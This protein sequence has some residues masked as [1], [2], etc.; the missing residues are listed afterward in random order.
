MWPELH[1][2]PSTTLNL[3]HVHWESLKDT[4]FT[5]VRGEP[6]YW[7]SPLLAVF[8]RRGMKMKMLPSRCSDFQWDPTFA[9]AKCQCLTDR[10]SVNTFT[11]MGGR[12]KLLISMFCLADIFG[13]GN[14]ITMFLGMKYIHNSL[15][16]YLIYK[17]II[18]RLLETSHELTQFLFPIFHT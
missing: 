8:Y 13:S 6:E 12:N 17:I 16:C 2:Y 18:F 7:E 1:S 3:Y 10:S 11:V 15:K 5:L 4:H 9:E 14:L